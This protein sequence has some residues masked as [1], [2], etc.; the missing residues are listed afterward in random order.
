MKTYE[1]VKKKVENAIGPLKRSGKQFPERESL[2]SDKKELASFLAHRIDHTL[3]RPEST[4][5]EVRKLCEEAREYGFFSVCVN[6][7][8]VERCRELL[9]G[10]HSVVCTVVGFPLGQNLPEVKAYEAARLKEQGAEEFDMVL[11]ISALRVEDYQMVYRDI[12]QVVEA[13]SPLSVKVILE[14]CFLTDDEKVAACFSAK[15][16]GADFVKTSTGFGKGGATVDDVRLMRLVVGPAMAIKAAGGIKTR[17]DAL[18]MLEAGANR[19]GTS[20]G[21]QIV[22]DQ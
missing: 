11:N 5:Y 7:F 18:A 19:I 22:L 15:A 10:S 20:S 1:E 17:S 21:V 2:P 8:H 9:E 13:V 6:P 4:A 14:N 16:A 3:L 12:I